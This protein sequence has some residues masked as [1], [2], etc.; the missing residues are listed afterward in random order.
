VDDV[1]R[2]NYEEP[3][4]EL[5]RLGGAVK[6]LRKQ[7]GLKQIELATAAGMSESQISDIERGKNSPGWRLLVRV[8]D[9]LGVS[10]AEFGQAY[11]RQEVP[12]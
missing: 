2:A 3:P 10:L 7:Q 4:P 12:S 9:G 6:E 8:I 5:L 11:D 1:P